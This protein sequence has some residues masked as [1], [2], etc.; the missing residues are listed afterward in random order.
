MMTM[1]CPFS[2]RLF[3]SLRLR[4][5]FPLILGDFCHYDHVQF[6]S[7]VLG[8]FGY[9]EHVPCFLQLGDFGHG[10]YVLSF[11]L[12]LFDFDHYDLIMSLHWF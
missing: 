1:S 11:S 10:D 8:D 9:R 5:I 3:R 7:L 2:F 12:V 6:F 4:S